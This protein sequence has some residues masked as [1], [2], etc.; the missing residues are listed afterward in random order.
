VNTYT[1]IVKQLVSDA[2]LS[3]PD[4]RSDNPSGSYTIEAE[5]ADM[6]L[7]KF[8]RQR[9]IGCLDDFEITCTPSVVQEQMARMPPK[10]KINGWTV[11]PDVTIEAVTEAVERHMTSLDNPG[12]CLACGTEV[13]GVE[14]DA[15]GYECEACG[16]TAVYGAE[17]LLICMAV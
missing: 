17:E 6:A 13:D 16:A 9:A 2:E 4:D 10:L 8:H 11:H 12:F 15:T 5:S 1:I 3:K 7:D 14:P